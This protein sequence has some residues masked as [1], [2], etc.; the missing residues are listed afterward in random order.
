MWHTPQYHL[1]WTFWTR[2][3]FGEIGVRA[4]STSR[5]CWTTKRFNCFSRW[6]ESS[7]FRISV[8]LSHFCVLWFLMSIGW[9]VLLPFQ[10]YLSHFTL[11]IPIDLLWRILSQQRKQICQSP[12]VCV[13][14]TGTEEEYLK[15]FFCRED[16][17][18]LRMIDLS[19][20]DEQTFCEPTSWL[21]I[22][23][24][25]HKGNKNKK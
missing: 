9:T 14:V 3:F 13:S 5:N 1:L 15:M 25:Q 4:V 18:L 7:P 20:S 19:R 2:D 11:L 16:C 17:V 12:F 24:H 8:Y 22:N 21:Q 23:C 10:Y 6:K